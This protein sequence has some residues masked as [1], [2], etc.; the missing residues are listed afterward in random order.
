[1][2]AQDL[3]SAITAVFIIGMVWFRTRMHYLHRGGLKLQR[4]GRL[5]FGGVL[6]LLAVGWFAAPPLGRSI[7]PGAGD[8]STIMRLLW[9]L[10]TYY[11]F[12]VIH[13]A[14]KSRRIEVF[15][16]SEQP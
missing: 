11:V 7:W 12:I 3:A 5:Y 9:F 2:R 13:R 16:A 1:M 10:A 14:L 4:A 6:A 8:D 15:G